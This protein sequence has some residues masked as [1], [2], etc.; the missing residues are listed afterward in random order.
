[1]MNKEYY[2]ACLKE[3]CEDIKLEYFPQVQ[4]RDLLNR[5][6]TLR[7]LYVPAS[8]KPMSQVKWKADF[9]SKREKYKGES[10]ADKDHQI[11]ASQENV[12]REKVEV[13][14][15]QPLCILADPGTGKT[16]LCKRTILAIIEDDRAFLD[17]L[18]QQ[19][20]IG[21]PQKAIPILLNF[22]S[23]DKMKALIK[24]DEMYE[25]EQLLY[26]FACD[27]LEE[28]CQKSFQ[29]S[30]R[31]KVEYADF[32]SMLREH[33]IVLFLDGW[34]ELLDVNLQVEMDHQIGQYINERGGS[35]SILMTI[36]KAY[37]VPSFLKNS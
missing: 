26:M 12:M 2:L 20:H 34:D 32:L 31:E 25:F 8:L 17:D 6:I 27:I 19:T 4:S 35:L 11:D 16:L 37:E 21:F 1:M 3:Y 33:P 28:F 14:I 15:P 24:Q 23:P 13:E 36:R 18:Y 10:S 5:K 29:E 22:R 7:N 30:F 9:D